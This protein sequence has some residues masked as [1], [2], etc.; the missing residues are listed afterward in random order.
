MVVNQAA[1]QFRQ[2]G[3]VIDDVETS[4]PVLIYVLSGSHIAAL[5]AGL[6]FLALTAFRALAGQYS[7][8]NVDGVA[9]AAMWWY[10][11]VF[12]YAF[13]WIGVFIAK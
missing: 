11:M 12:L 7:S 6:L 8:R 10:A 5:I 1:F 13:L 3:L 2:M 4:A 9:A